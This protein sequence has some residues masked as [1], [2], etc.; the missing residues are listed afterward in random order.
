[1][2]ITITETVLQLLKH[3]KLDDKVLLLVTDDG[4]GKY[5]LQGGA[6]S[7]GAKFTL[8]VLDEPDQLYQ[9]KLENNAN[10]DLYTSDY[11]LV[12]FT[13]GLTLDLQHYQ[14]TL[15]DNGGIL[16]GAVQIANGQDIIAAF[17][18]GTTANN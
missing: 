9:I 6:C 4:G 15:K 10:L 18:K 13:D 11:D 3:K 2:K 1:M 12:F 17:N 8:I 16:D 7:I 14:I 5:S